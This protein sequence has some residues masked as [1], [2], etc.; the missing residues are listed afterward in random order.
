MLT[1]S[2]LLKAD[3]IKNHSDISLTFED[4]VDILLGAIAGGNTIQR[5]GNTIFLCKP[6]NNS[7]LEFHSIN[8]DK[9]E[10]LSLNFK[11]LIEKAKSLGYKYV[12][13]FYDN[14]RVSELLEASGI[15]C[16]VKKIDQGK[17][18]TYQMIARF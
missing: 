9:G 13:T 16:E 2:E 1:F 4:A 3:C 12:I 15:E 17:Y 5:F 7:G 10:L 18:N 14:P 11:M 8:A 6:H